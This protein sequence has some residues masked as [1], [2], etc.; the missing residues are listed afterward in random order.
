MNLYQQ[1]N[2]R[3][4]V[5]P[6]LLTPM[7]SDLSKKTLEII[8]L[9]AQNVC[10]FKLKKKKSLN[11]SFLGSLCK[12]MRIFVKVCGKA[13]TLLSMMGK[14]LVVPIAQVLHRPLARKMRGQTTHPRSLCVPG[15]RSTPCLEARVNWMHAP[16][17]RH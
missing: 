4:F 12:K 6:S 5:Y 13:E 10:L 16:L 14:G 15:L 1:C 17:P 7:N 3:S 11:I 8:P 2:H 9:K